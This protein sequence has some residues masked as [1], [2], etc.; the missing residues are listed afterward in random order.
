[1]PMGLKHLVT[2][3]CTLPQFKRSPTPP[4]HQFTVFSVIG[5]DDKVV[6]KYAQC[7]NCGIVHRVTEINKSD[8]MPGKESSNAIIKVSDI[9]VSLPARLADILE[10]N[11]ADLPTWEQA[12][13]IM[14]NKRWGEFVVLTT[15]SDEG[16]R[17]G[18]YLRILGENMYDVSGFERNEV[19]NE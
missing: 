4:M 13:F 3:R 16:V 12:K 15:E 8:I 1:M 11:D 18:K 10:G 5:D 17:S 6:P 7:N 2:C 14:D 9:K 19:A